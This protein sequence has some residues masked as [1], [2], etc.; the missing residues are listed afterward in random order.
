M[1]KCVSGEIFMQSKSI[2]DNS[3]VGVTGMSDPSMSEMSETSD[4]KFNFQ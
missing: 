1:K 3:A 4:P 2:F